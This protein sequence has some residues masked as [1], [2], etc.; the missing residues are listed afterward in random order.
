[1]KAHELARQ[2]L[3]GPDHEVMMTYDYG[4]H[5]HTL[6]AKPIDAPKPAVVREWPYG[7]CFA[8][9]E[10]VYGQTF[11]T[12]EEWQETTQPTCDDAPVTR[13]VAIVL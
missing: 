1:M 3:D 11:D 8:V 2:L 13:R 9:E 7:R 12:I 4:D 6:A 5:V 10:D